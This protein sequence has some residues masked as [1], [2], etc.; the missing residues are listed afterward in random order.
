MRIRVRREEAVQLPEQAHFRFQVQLG[1]GNAGRGAGPAA[2][3]QHLRLLMR[4]RFSPGH[5]E[6]VDLAGSVD[7]FGAGEQAFDGDDLN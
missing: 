4:R 7:P 1:N 5:R 2:K 6:G 3:L